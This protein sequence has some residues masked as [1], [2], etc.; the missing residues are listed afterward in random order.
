MSMTALVVIP[1]YVAEDPAN[2]EIR[3]VVDRRHRDRRHGQ[4]RHGGHRVEQRRGKRRFSTFE[5]RVVVTR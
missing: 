5:A 3:V 1:R 2:L 4:A